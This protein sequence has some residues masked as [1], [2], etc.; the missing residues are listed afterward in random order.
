MTIKRRDTMSTYRQDLFDLDI[1]LDIE[2]RDYTGSDV[3]TRP[4]VE[5]MRELAARG[6]RFVVGNHPTPKHTVYGC[7]VA[8]AVKVTQLNHRLHGRCVRTIWA[9]PEGDN[10]NYIARLHTAP[11][12]HYHITDDSLDHLDESGRGYDT[13]A[14]A[15]RAAAKAGYTHVDDSTFGGRGRQRIPARY[16]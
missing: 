14:A 8:D 5:R 4:T 16:R 10:P 3:V 9:I 1:D 2:F 7:P 12:G 11:T 6:Y 13:K 15:M